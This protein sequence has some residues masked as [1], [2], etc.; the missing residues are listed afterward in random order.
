MVAGDAR[1]MLYNARVGVFIILNLLLV[2]LIVV[3]IRVEIQGRVKPA[4]TSTSQSD[5]T[6]RKG[7]NNHSGSK[8]RKAATLGGV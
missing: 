5:V 1:L 6:S 4:P 8:C 2:R 7:G 3:A